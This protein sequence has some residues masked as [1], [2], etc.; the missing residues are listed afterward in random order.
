MSSVPEVPFPEQY[1]DRLK[2]P[3]AH[4][5]EVVTQ[6][7][8]SDC[9]YIQTAQMIQI[10]ASIQ[11]GSR[12]LPL[13]WKQ[14]TNTYPAYRCKGK[15]ARPHT[16][17]KWVAKRGLPNI[18]FKVHWM[19]RQQAY[20][21]PHMSP[22]RTEWKNLQQ[23]IDAI[24]ESI[25]RYGP[26][27]T[28]IYVDE[29]FSKWKDGDLPYEWDGRK[30]YRHQVLI[31]GWGTV[32]GVP[33]WLVQNS[34]GNINGRALLPELS[35]SYESLFAHRLNY[36]WVAI[37]TPR[38]I[39][40]RCA[41]GAEDHAMAAKVAFDPRDVAQAAESP[42]AFETALDVTAPKPRPSLVVVVMATLALLF[43]LAVPNDQQ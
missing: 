33:S 26:C 42:L 10:R 32:Q 22:Y 41:S 3:Y 6:G 14:W 5:F 40:D 36:V 9:V 20:L 35:K 7:S 27:M 2:R 18:A 38:H 31:L 19:P 37:L 16:F 21:T 25:M 23:Q 8:C 15:G 34:Y 28:T 30:K 4:S 17:L 24:K 39:H 43:V 13:A 1:D 29:T 11:L 12:V